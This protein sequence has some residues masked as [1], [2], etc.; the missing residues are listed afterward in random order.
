MK[1]IT[2]D[3][4]FDIVGHCGIIQKIYV[5]IVTSLHMFTAF[6]MV[7]NIYTGGFR[8]SGV[9]YPINLLFFL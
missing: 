2:S 3:E 6:H 1:S 8:R 7:A 5:L 9:L 4:A